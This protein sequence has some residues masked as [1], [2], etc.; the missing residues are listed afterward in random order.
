MKLTLPL[1]MFSLTLLSAQTALAG[2]DW[3]V[4]YRARLSAAKS[5]PTTSLQDA[6]KP[7]VGASAPVAIKASSVEH[8]RSH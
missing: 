8:P 3:D 7:E 5:H 4:I 6:Q 2:P 1:F